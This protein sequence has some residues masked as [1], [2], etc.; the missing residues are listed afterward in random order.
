MVHIGVRHVYLLV[1]DHLF[2]PAGIQIN[3][4]T[5]AAAEIGEVLDREPKAA[6]PS[7]AHHEPGATARKMFI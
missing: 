1:R 7:R 4:V 3:K 2:Y 6:G 5:D